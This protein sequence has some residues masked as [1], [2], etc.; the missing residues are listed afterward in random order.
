VAWTADPCSS[1]LS[2]PLTGEE[3]CTEGRRAAVVSCQRSSGGRSRILLRSSVRN[4]GSSSF[5]GNTSVAPSDQLTATARSTRLTPVTDRA[6]TRE[7]PSEG[8]TLQCLAAA[9]AATTATAGSQQHR[10]S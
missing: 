5:E 9:V 4:L 8:R 1:S 6:A 3:W 2:T 10:G 7:L